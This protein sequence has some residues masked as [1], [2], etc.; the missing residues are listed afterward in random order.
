MEL[1]C[2]DNRGLEDR[3]TI[4]KTYEGSIQ[5][6]VDGSLDKA[7]WFTVTDDKGQEECDFYEWRFSTI[8]NW[9]EKQLDKILI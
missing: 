2:S 7:T 9:R 1:I 3:L 8:Q 6:V 5:S 4:G